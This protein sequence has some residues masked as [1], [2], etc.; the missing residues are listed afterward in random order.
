MTGA[1]LEEKAGMYQHLRGTVLAKPLAAAYGTAAQVT[2]A[3]TDFTTTHAVIG[4]GACT[5]FCWNF[6]LQGGYFSA[7]VGGAGWLAKGPYVGYANQ[8]HHGSDCIFVA[9]GL[10][11]AGG[12]V[13][14]CNGAPNG[15]DYEIDG[16]ACAHPGFAGGKMTPVYS[17]NLNPILGRIFGW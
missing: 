3:A 14:Q 6:S 1:C 11:P 16:F 8:P 13:T 10:Y 17:V 5:G 7:Q 15:D 12:N 4:F 2:G 9:G